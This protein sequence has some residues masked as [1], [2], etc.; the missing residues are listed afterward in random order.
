MLNLPTLDDSLDD[1]NLH[2]SLTFKYNY[3]TSKSGQRVIDTIAT[4]LRHLDEDDVV[5]NLKGIGMVKGSELKLSLPIQ[6]LYKEN[7]MVDEV[8][9]Y[10]QMNDWL[11]NKLISEVVDSDLH[12]MAIAE[13]L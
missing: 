5:V 8:N 2:L 11:T 10:N 4:S 7:G 1:S 6:A 3:K 9:L 12:E 13:E